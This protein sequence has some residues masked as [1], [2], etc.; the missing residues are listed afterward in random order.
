MQL[1]TPKQVKTQETKEKIYKAA[2]NILKKKGFAYLTVSNIC[3]V[4]GVSNGTFFYHFKTKDDL[5]SY[6]IFDKF[7]EY[8][9]NKHFDESV[10]GL[11]FDRRIVCYYRAWTEYM[12]EI[13]IDFFTNFYNTSNH[14]LDV[15]LF[16]GRTPITMWNFPG[17]CLAEA[18]NE[19]L[20]KE[21]VSITH[22]A[23]VLATIVKGVAFDWCLS[24]GVF[25]MGD[26]LE[27]IMPP[28]LESICKPVE[29]TE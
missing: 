4:A 26:R 16:N 3:K 2:D 11:S 18:E 21:N 6:Y 22:A 1:K 14:S 24:G 5:L 28:Y 23:E 12:N 19:G 13:G 29:K 17:S 27:E 10:E 8:R 7:A 25:N 15:R 20:L 9:L